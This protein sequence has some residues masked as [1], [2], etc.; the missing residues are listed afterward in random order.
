[1]ADT[2]SF[3]DVAA[4]IEG[5]GGSFDFASQGNAEE[6]IT[7]ES[8]NDINTMTVGADGE[9]MHN[10]AADKSAS[11]TVRLLKTSALNK[12]LMELYKYQTASSKY[13]G[14]NTIVVSNIVTG[15]L[16]TLTGCAFKKAPSNTYA[17]EGGTVEWVFDVAKRETTLGDSSVITTV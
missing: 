9:V 5:P 16:E 8:A 11:V 7:I 3:L 17:K 14:K 4:S 1:M 13:H 12:K 10:L 2:Y 6:G 15:D